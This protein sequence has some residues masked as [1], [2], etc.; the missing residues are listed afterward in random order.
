MNMDE[1]SNGRTGMFVSGSDRP[2]IEDSLIKLRK[3][4]KKKRSFAG[5]MHW[6]NVL[7]REF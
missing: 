1:D 4:V 5:I 2:S 3:L 7:I 6:W